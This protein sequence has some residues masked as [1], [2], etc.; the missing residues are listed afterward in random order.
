MQW[1][2]GS[3]AQLRP[4]PHPFLFPWGPQSVAKPSPECL[5][6]ALDVEDQAGLRI[7]C[8][9]QGRMHLFLFPE[10]PEQELKREQGGLRVGGGQAGRWG[11][12][13]EDPHI[14][15]RPPAWQGRCPSD[16]APSAHPW[17]VRTPGQAW[18]ALSLQP[19]LP[20]MGPQCPP[21]PQTSAKSRHPT[22]LPTIQAKGRERGFR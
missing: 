7:A 18:P 13:P 3:G 11:G 12:G 8:Q 1:G 15:F 9:L 6:V 16:S 10:L 20:A 14:P 22:D 21:V 19:R 2:C 4:L 5:V 17:M